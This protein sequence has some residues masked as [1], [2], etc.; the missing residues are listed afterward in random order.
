[1][2]IEQ[3]IESLEHYEIIKLTYLTIE[4]DN[5]FLLRFKQIIFQRDYTL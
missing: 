2:L 5:Y 3:M 1:M 4:K